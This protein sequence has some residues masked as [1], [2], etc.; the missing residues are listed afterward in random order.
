VTLLSYFV[1]RSVLS[2]NRGE[3]LCYPATQFYEI[4]VPGRAPIC[5]GAILWIV[6]ELHPCA[7]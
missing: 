4:T 3:E 2:P 7:R 1:N 5:C 6:V